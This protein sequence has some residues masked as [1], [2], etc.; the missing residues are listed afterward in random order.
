MSKE[1]ELVAGVSYL[2]PNV[3]RS[4]S[5]TRTYSLGNYKNIKFSDTISDI[6]EDLAIN[7]EVMNVLKFL[8]LVSIEKS[9]FDYVK[10]AE[11]WHNLDI[12]DAI[13]KLD[14]LESETMSTLKELLNGKKIEDLN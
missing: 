2:R 5:V 10:D 4:I 12:E 7:H 9:Y 6:P 8:Q 14:G 3:S 13:A 1:E 11:A